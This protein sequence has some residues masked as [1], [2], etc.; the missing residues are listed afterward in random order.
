MFFWDVGANIGF[1]SWLVRSVRPEAERVLFEPDAL[2]ASLLRPTV[3]AN[4]LD[5][6]T[7][8][9]IALSNTSGPLEFKRY[10]VSGATGHLKSVDTSGDPAT[11]QGSCAAQQGEQV[12]VECHTLDGLIASG[13]VAPDLIKIDVEMAEFLVVEGG[14]RLFATQSPMVLVEIFDPRVIEFFASR[15]YDLWMI[16][17]SAKNY[18]AAPA[19]MFSEQALMAPYR[20]EC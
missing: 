8:R 13:M 19:G 10:R 9:E 6:V 3:S 5:R 18:F 20:R 11:I 17:E 14:E 2:N 12:L 7:V 1:F 4:S 16:D 15:G